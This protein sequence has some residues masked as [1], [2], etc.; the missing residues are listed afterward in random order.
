MAIGTV[1]LQSLDVQR[2]EDHMK[3]TVEVAQHSSRSL[4]NG[5]AAAG[6]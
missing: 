1:R 5:F 6:S 3:L 4:L 2:V